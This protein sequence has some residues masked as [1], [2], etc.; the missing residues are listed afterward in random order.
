[1][2]YHYPK[3][4][5]EMHTASQSR[6]F[7]SLEKAL[8]QRGHSVRPK[9]TQHGLLVLVPGSAPSFRVVLENA[10]LATH[11]L[12]KKSEGNT[13]INVPVI[14][15]EIG[16]NTCVNTT[17][18]SIGRGDD[19][20]IKLPE[21]EEYLSVLQCEFKI[22][23][24]HNMLYLYDRS[25]RNTTNVEGTLHKY[26]FHQH[27]SRVGLLPS[28]N[29]ILRFGS[30]GKKEADYRFRIMWLR[31]TFDAHE[32]IEAANRRRPRNALTITPP[33]PEQGYNLR[34]PGDKKQ[35]E[36]N[37]YCEV[38]MIGEGG[39]GVVYKSMNLEN[40]KIVATKQIECKRFL[41]GEGSDAAWTDYRGARREIKML[42]SLKHVSNL[43][44]CSVTS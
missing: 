22:D 6:E 26:N 33:N 14:G 28:V 20:T 30:P 10:H 11:L 24:K 1:M 34:I 39:S 17:L 5:H 37:K 3:K 42:R 2:S 27:L 13:T 7:N 9:P 40:G 36:W 4:Q 23:E 32:F 16:S 44:W 15:L 35:Q 41:F 25:S 8:K 19:C 38:S 31:D 43:H 12:W 29:N 18:A 21:A